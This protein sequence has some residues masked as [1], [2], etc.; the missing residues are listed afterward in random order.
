MI[1][2]HHGL[3]SFIELT[4]GQMASPQSAH[5]SRPQISTLHHG[6]QAL[7]RSTA[8]GWTHCSHAEHASLLHRDAC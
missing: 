1:V 3:Q 7:L 2:V 6:A 8:G 5:S 4:V